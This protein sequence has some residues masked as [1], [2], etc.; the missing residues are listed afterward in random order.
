MTNKEIKLLR[1]L[2]SKKG[3]AEAGLFVV[4][5][6]KLVK[7]ALS[8]SFEVAAVY[9][10]EQIG[11]ETMARISSLTSPSPVLATV[12]IPSVS[13]RIPTTPGL[14][15]ALDSVRDPGNLG[16]I[17]RIADW[18]GVQAVLLSDDCAEIYNPKVIQASMGSIFRVPMFTAPLISTI[19]DF[20]SRGIEVFG[21][22]LEG[23]DIYSA[24]LPST[25]LVIMGNEANGIRREI[26]AE[27][28]RKLT[29][30]SFGSGAESLNVAVATAITTSEFIRR[31][32]N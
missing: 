18:F 9:R 14:Y 31:C 27:V 21:T 15:L 1:S 25:A 29:I 22:F 2:S 26:E 24:Q 17:I 5:G 19:K 6:E 28:E 16:T 4:E 8:S 3:R 13:D 10:S 11:I 12:R 23:E 30:P 7:E 32:K 20:R